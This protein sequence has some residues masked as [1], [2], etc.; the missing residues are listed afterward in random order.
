MHDRERQGIRTK[1][2]DH[3]IVDRTK[4]RDGQGVNRLVYVVMAVTVDR[5][6]DILGIWASDGGEGQ[7]GLAAGGR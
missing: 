7:S 2:P 1:G 3:K 5:H 4:I 6:R